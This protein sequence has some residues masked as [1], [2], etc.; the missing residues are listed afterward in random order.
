MEFRLM[1]RKGQE[2]C[3]S[4]FYKVKITKIALYYIFSAL[5]YIFSELYYIF[6]EL[7]YIFSALYYIKMAV[8]S[9]NQNAVILSCILLE[10]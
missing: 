1:F 5:Y 10:Y 8:F 4:L 3:I 2:R 9:T 7:N 6:Y